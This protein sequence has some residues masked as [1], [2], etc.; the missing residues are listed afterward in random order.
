MLIQCQL[1]AHP[2]TL[3]ERFESHSFSLLYSNKMAIHNQEPLLF[4]YVSASEIR[5][6]FLFNTYN[7]LLKIVSQR[8]LLENIF[9]ALWWT[10]KY[11]PA[12]VR[13]G[14]AVMQGW[15]NNFK[16]KKITCFQCIKAS[17]VTSAG[18]ANKD[19]GRTVVRDTLFKSPAN[20]VVS[21]HMMS[22]SP[23]LFDMAQSNHP[24]A[25]KGPEMW[26]NFLELNYWCE[27]FSIDFNRGVFV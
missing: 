7:I 23:Q 16:Q 3:S 21:N 8:I 12:T 9:Y 4:S 2:F 19:N 27:L 13:T 14:S 5:I 15:R 17:S 26:V 22:A 6:Y 25:N 20:P 18:Q 1:W 24:A 10:L 11:N